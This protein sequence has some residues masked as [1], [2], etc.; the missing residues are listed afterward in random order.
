MIKIKKL[1]LYIGIGIVSIPVFIA[2]YYFIA[3]GPNETDPTLSKNPVYKSFDKQ[4]NKTVFEEESEGGQSNNLIIKTDNDT[5]E[6]SYT[7]YIDENN[8]FLDIKF[9]AGDGFSGGGYELKIVKN[10]HQLSPYHY[11]DVIRPFDFLDTGDYYKVL[12]S[13]L[14]LDKDS[15]KKGDTIFGYTAFKIQNRYGPEKYFEEGKGYFKAIV[16]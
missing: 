5:S 4:K 7:C 8:L 15:Y 13:R 3:W 9:S 14:V 2:A 1:L 16:N 6:E 11:T 10:R 12:D